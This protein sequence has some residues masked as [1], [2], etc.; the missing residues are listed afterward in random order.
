M[1]EMMIATYE[2]SLGKKLVEM[3]LEALEDNNKIH[4]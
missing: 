3:K 2:P 1:I 4:G